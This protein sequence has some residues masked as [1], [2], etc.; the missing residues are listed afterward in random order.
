MW[1]SSLAN[2]RIETE[3]FEIGT[4]EGIDLG[5]IIKGSLFFNVVEQSSNCESGLKN[6]KLE[7]RK[8]SI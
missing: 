8:V 5:F 2:L 4:E 7:L 6:L 3:E 1:L